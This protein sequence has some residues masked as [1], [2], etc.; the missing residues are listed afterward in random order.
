MTGNILTIYSGVKYY[1]RYRIISRET[2]SYNLIAQIVIA[3]YINRSY[4][5]N[6]TF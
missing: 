2:Y 3:I 5:K 6:I 4:K 1:L